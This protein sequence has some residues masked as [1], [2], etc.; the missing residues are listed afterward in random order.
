MNSVVVQAGFAGLANHLLFHYFEPSPANTPLAAVFLVLQP[1]LLAVLPRHTFITP[2]SLSLP[3]FW[4]TLALTYTTFVLTLA[5]SI[6]LYRLSPFHPLA[7]VPGPMVMKISKAYLL[8]ISMRGERHLVFKKLHDRYGDV[9]RTGP[10]EISICQVQAMTQVLGSSG[11]QKGKAYAVR[12]S[13]K[14]IPQSLVV[15]SSPS[16]HARKR[17]LWN[18][19]MSMQALK[20]YEVVMLQKGK[21]LVEVLRRCAT[22]ADKDVDLVKWIN[23]FTF[24]FMSEMAFGG[25]SSMLKDG[26]DTHGMWDILEQHARI[27]DALAQVPWLSHFVYKVF[28]FPFAKVGARW[29]MA[30]V[31]RGNSE[32][33]NA[34]GDG[35]G[36]E[37][38]DKM[39]LKDLWWYLTN[40]DN[41]DQDSLTTTSTSTKSKSKQKPHLSLPEVASEGIVAI[42]GGSDTTSSVLACLFWLLMIPDNRGWYERVREEIGRVYPKHYENYPKRQT[43]KEEEE[44][45][46]D[47]DWLEEFKDTKKRNELKVLGACIN[48]TLRLFPPTLTNGPR[49]VTSVEEERVVAGY[50]LPKGTEIYV[51]PYVIHRNPAYFS[52]PDRFDPGRWLD[53]VRTREG[54]GERDGGSE[55]ESESQGQNKRKG[56]LGSD[57]ISP[58]LGTEGETR[59]EPEPELTTTATHPKHIHTPLAY[60]P[61]SYGPRNCVGRALARQELLIIAALLIREFEFEFPRANGESGGEGESGSDWK[62]WP[63]RLKDYWVTMRGELKVVVKV[64]S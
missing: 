52:D 6:T 39:R 43:D 48:E 35:S 53:P 42:L 22:G 34:N 51:P 25:G 31:K 12:Q 59:P 37:N 18:H 1:L 49:E 56:K 41:Q 44:E 20:D 60:I 2:L 45:E 30:R 9:V 17:V 62:T 46:E 55:G 38:G 27:M 28:D 15:A 40:E 64:R 4:S 13:N 23:Y 29:A 26:K 16:L 63:D 7:N 54:E 14:S 32:S 10:N 8:W 19:G 36:D 50:F 58:G 5:S 47:W 24:D 11:F 3:S 33:V 21:E 61:F 57:I